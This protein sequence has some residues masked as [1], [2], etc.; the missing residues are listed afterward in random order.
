MSSEYKGSQAFNQ[1]F[2]VDEYINKNSG[3]LIL[4][5]PIVNLKGIN[6]HIGLKIS[7]AYSAAPSGSGVLG[8]P[9]NWGWSISYVMPGTNG[10]VTSQGKTS[11]IDLTWADSNGYQ[12]GIRYLNNNG[13]KFEPIVPPQLVPGRSTATYSFKYKYADGSVDYFDSTGKLLQHAD[14]YGNAINYYYTPEIGT[15]STC[16]LDRIVDSFGQT[17]QFSYDPNTIYVTTPDGSKTTILYS[18]SG[19]SQIEDPLGNKTLMQYTSESGDSVINQINYPT[20]LQTNIIYTAIG[21]YDTQGGTKTFP[22]VS[23]L[24]HLDETGAFMSQ[25]QYAY[26]VETAGNTYTGYNAGYRIGGNSDG[27]MESNNTTYRYDVRILKLDA[28]GNIL[29]GSLVYYNYLHVPILT[30]DFLVDGTNTLKKAYQTEYTYLVEPNI[31]ARQ[32]NFNRPIATVYSVWNGTDY[33]PMKKSTTSYDNFGQPLSS[34]EFL[35]DSSTQG[36]VSQ[37]SEVHTYVSASWGGEMPLASTYIDHIDNFEKKIDYTLTS[38]QKSVAGAALSY[39]NGSTGI[40]A[41]WKT[42]TY[43]YDSNGRLT[44]ITLAWSSGV[45]PPSNSIANTSEQYAYAFDDA[46]HELTVSMTD[47]NG[48]TTTHVYDVSKSG[49]PECKLTSPGGSITT[50][51]YDALG[52]RTKHTDPNG[53]VTQNTFLIYATGGK[54]SV[55]TLRADGYLNEAI[56]NAQGKTI[57][58]SDNG[59][60]TASTSTAVNRVLRQMTYNAIGL[61]KIKTDSLGLINTYSYDAL[62]RVIEHIDPKENKTTTEHNDA[63]LTTT[64]KVNSVLHQNTV[65]DGV[66]RTI[67]VD[68]YPD[69]SAPGATYYHQTLI[70]YNGLGKKT[71]TSLN[72]M[73]ISDDSLIKEL[74]EHSFTYDPDFK[75]TQETFKGYLGTNQ[76]NTTRDMVYELQNH[77][78]S[79]SKSIEYVGGD[80]YSH[81]GGIN[82]YNA[83]GQLVSYQNQLGDTESYAYNSDGRRSK[84]TRFG[85]ASFQYEYDANGNMTKMTWADGNRLYSYNSDNKL[86]S[87]TEGSNTMS[88]EYYLDGSLKQVSFPSGETQSYQ[89]DEYSRIVGQ[90]DASGQTLTNVY[91]SYS[92]L[93]SRAYKGDT[94]DFNFGVVNGLKNSLTGMQMSGSESYS[95]S[96]SFDGFNQLT[97]RTVKNS[98]QDVILSEAL[99][100][101]ALGRITSLSLQ[102]ATQ[103]DNAALNLTK[104]FRYDGLNQLSSED[105]TYANSDPSDSYS[106]VYDGNSNVLSSVENGTTKTFTYNDLDQLSLSGITYDKDGRLITDAQGNTYAYD[107]FDHLISVTPAGAKTLNSFGYHPNGALAESQNSDRPLNFFYDSA[108]LNAISE[109]TSSSEGNEVSSPITNWTTFL[110]SS[111]QRES[112]YTSG[113]SSYYHTTNRSTALLADGSKEISIKYSPYGVAT[114]SD[115]IPASK[116]FTW[117]QEY[118]DPLTNLV[119]LRAR[120][121][122]PNQMHFLTMDSANRDNLYSYCEA[123]PINAYDP[124]GHSAVVDVGAALAISAV[125]GIV[126]TVATGGAAG[127]IAA[128][129]FGAE[130][131][132]A[133]ISV[134]VIAG[135]AGSVAGDATFAGLRGEKFTAG[136]AMIDLASGGAAGAVGAGVG[137][138]VGKATMRAAFSRGL[139]QAAITRIG[140]VSSGLS[141]GAA[142]SLAAAGVISGAY[143]QP[144]FSESTAI[145]F[146]VGAAAGAGGG[147]L[148]SMA[149]HGFGPKRTIPLPVEED[150]FGSINWEVNLKRDSGGSDRRWLHFVKK[151]EHAEDI[152]DSGYAA[153]RL[154]TSGSEHY[155]TIDIHGFKRGYLINTDYNGQEA[156]RPISRKNFNKYLGQRPGLYGGKSSVDPVK[157]L[158]CYGAYSNAQALANEI[159]RPI[160]A[161]YPSMGISDVVDWKTFNPK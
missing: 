114:E 116:N 138:A 87:V 12:S 25:T 107:E 76:V 96:L 37:M 159:Q 17:T 33:V 38:D 44:E 111:L 27:L 15:V 79:Y 93:S 115:S 103:S 56:M 144:F 156:Y 35:Y 88:Y 50:Y 118:Q 135:A 82:K 58:V 80:T 150:E 95:R 71:G 132:A 108:F 123:D 49:G 98:N 119:Y 84:L 31:H 149:Y 66:G 1:M 39:R 91:N 152:S 97:S 77:E 70:S 48:N 127:A 112:A 133:S 122:D 92:Q 32:V 6:Q 57:K 94:I 99:D 26:G 28:S 83:A 67:Q 134:G 154:N 42:K 69:T 73:K 61:L 5:K 129:V 47:P 109:T 140:S 125:V 41:A 64:I 128:D 113:Q 158:S 20:G 101:D 85:G 120:F 146:A 145:S 117:N 19:I 142:G 21:Y 147:L 43:T 90:T 161:G 40:W 46:S 141:G 63:A 126:A 8:L 34:E 60:P 3:S 16:L 148:G 89:L 62:G 18:A 86:L 110:S 22:A 24:T 2:L 124:T 160:F 53:N 136:R 51:E 4:S 104:T 131:V 54:N 139:S 75:V 130:C 155:D 14:I 55:T 13:V 153:M 11:V 106:F 29:S 74:S 157:L 52:R 72:Q 102:S 151:S 137:S 59:D 78:I 45:H 68:V 36:F 81:N 10:T 9:K 23:Q 143:H 30:Q 121:Y 100:R 65:K 105:V 7:L